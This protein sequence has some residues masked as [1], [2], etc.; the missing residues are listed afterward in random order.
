MFRMG[1]MLI[2]TSYPP[3]PAARATSEG[4]GN[5]RFTLHYIRLCR[6]WRICLV[7]GTAQQEYLSPPFNLGK[8]ML[9]IIDRKI[10]PEGLQSDPKTIVDHTP[11]ILSQCSADL[12]YVYVSNACA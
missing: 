11:F 9:T 12:R 2:R 5:A 10:Q 8:C 7:A 3:Q 6:I 4:N 1:L